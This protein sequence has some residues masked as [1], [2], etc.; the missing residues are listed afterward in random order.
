V[1]ETGAEE[2]R[3]LTWIFAGPSGHA[4]RRGQNRRQEQGPLGR[5]GETSQPH[6]DT[7]VHTLTGGLVLSEDSFTLKLRMTNGH[8]GAVTSMCVLGVL[9]AVSSSGFFFFFCDTGA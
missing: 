4:G 7:C 6:T 3:A 1:N 9:P 8:C 5:P 2:E